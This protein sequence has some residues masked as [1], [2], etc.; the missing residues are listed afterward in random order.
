MS[1]ELLARQRL[2]IKEIRGALVTAGLTSL[3]QQAAALGVARSTAWTILQ[4]RHK[5]SGLSTGLIIRMLY[6]SQLPPVVRSKLQEYVVEKSAGLYGHGDK[7]L[8]DFKSKLLRS[9][10]A[11]LLVANNS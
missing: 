6:S 2:K 10:L 9:G 3:D 11:D 4:A 1:A 7:R 8:R 5:K